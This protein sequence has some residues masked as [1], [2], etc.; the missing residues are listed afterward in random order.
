MEFTLYIRSVTREGWMCNEW[1]KMILIYT[2]C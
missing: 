1:K 2:T